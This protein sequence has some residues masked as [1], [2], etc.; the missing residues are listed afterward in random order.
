MVSPIEARVNLGIPY[1]DLGEE[2]RHYLEMRSSGRDLGIVV[3]A[4]LTAPL[5]ASAPPEPG[6]RPRIVSANVDPITIDEAVAQMLAPPRGDRARM[7]H[8]VHPHA[9]NLAAFDADHRER[10]ARADVVLPDG[11]GIRLAARILGVSVP[12]NVNGTDVLPLLCRAAVDAHVPLALVGA[13]P[14]IADACAQELRAQTAGLEIPLVSHGYLDDEGRRAIVA[15]LTELGR[16][17][18]LVG[19]GSPLQEKFAW[20]WLAP[21][22]QASVVTVGGLFDFFSG[23]MPR[24]PMAWR[25]LGLEWVYRMAQEP[26]RLGKR[27]L[28]GNPLFVALAVAQRLGLR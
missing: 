15:R 9:L 17:I 24:A 7:I 8:F 26:R 11:S 21:L 3:R 5:A 4:L 14:G 2:E 22:E 28:L 1:S 6:A 13:A 27:Y 23:R 10:L 18:V 20:E 16:V 19:M 25:E 12:H